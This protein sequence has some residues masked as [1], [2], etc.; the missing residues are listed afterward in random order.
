MNGMTFECRPAVKELELFQM[1][2]NAIGSHTHT[3]TLLIPEE[4]KE[5]N[6]GWPST[7]P[8]A[9]RELRRSYMYT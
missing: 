4:S 8:H 2:G 7:P 5:H 3:H 1:Q 9:L 6:Q